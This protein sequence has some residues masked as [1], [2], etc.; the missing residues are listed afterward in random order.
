[1]DQD[2]DQPTLVELQ[3]SLF[4][5]RDVFHTY[6]FDKVVNLVKAHNM[7]PSHCEMC[8][9]VVPYANHDCGFFG[10]QSKGVYLS[11][12]ADYTVWYQRQHNTRD[13]NT[14]KVVILQMV[15]GKVS[16]FDQ[17]RDGAPPATSHLTTWSSMY[18]T[19]GL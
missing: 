19:R 18:G 5:V 13:G 11:K 7:R 17:R 3:Q 6:G 1:M 2:Q 8:R 10:D 16:H 12:L 4:M 9:D 14:G 15:T